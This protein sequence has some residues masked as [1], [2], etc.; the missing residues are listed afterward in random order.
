MNAFK[1]N[2]IDCVGIKCK[3]LQII[4]TIEIFFYVTTEDE[5]AIKYNFHSIDFFIWKDIVKIHKENCD[6][7]ELFHSD[8]IINENNIKNSLDYYSFTLKSKDFNLQRNI[9]LIFYLSDEKGWDNIWEMVNK[10]TWEN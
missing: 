2:Y 1:V 6:N 5:F 7:A 8:C 9:N 4:N 10:N 3:N